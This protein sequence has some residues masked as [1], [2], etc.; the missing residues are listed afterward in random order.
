MPLPKDTLFYGFAPKLTDEQRIYVDSIFDN[1]LTIVNARSG[2]GKT[3]LAV[4]AAHMLGDPLLY[5]FAPV[6]EGSLGYTPGSVEEKEAKYI[7]PLLDALDEINEDPRFSLWREDNPDLINDQTWIEAKSHVFMRGTNI[8]RK[9][10]IIDEAQ[11]LTRGD[12]KK[13]L[14]RA[15][16]SS[17]VIMIGHHAQCDLPQPAKSGF[18]PY[19]EHFRDE[20]YANVCELTRNFRGQ[21]AQK[22]DALTW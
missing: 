10:I 9:T 16:D 8:K 19:L 4:A 12:L 22:A 7:T 5:L 14:T 13:I 15:H 21:L 20:P 17:R 18:V 6:Q 1:L 3:T 11:N 2:T